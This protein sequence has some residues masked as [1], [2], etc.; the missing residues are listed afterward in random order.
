M[1]KTE[2]SRGVEGWQGLPLTEGSTPSPALKTPGASPTK[3][4]T[5]T[6][7]RCILNHADAWDPEVR[8]CER[9]ATHLWVRV[10]KSPIPCCSKGI[11]PGRWVEPITTTT[12]TT[13]GA[14]S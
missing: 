1:T 13:E 3:E 5:V 9:P 10:G 2:I 6:T 14:T 7:T 4:D 11:K 12:T 8:S